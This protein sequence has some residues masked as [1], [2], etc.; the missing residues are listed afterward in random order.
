MDKLS[1]EVRLLI[2]FLLVGVVLTVSNYLSPTPAPT[3]TKQEAKTP[4]PVAEATAVPTATPPPAEA[5]LTAQVQG[6]QPTDFAINTNV[7]TV[8]F[9]NRGATVR[10]WI[11]N[12]Y[13]DSNGKPLD[14]V[15]QSALTGKNGKPVPAPFSLYFKQQ[16]SV[17]LNNKLYKVTKSDD[18]LGVTFEWSDGRITSKKTFQFAKDSYLVNVTSLVIENGMQLPHSMVWRGGFGDM[19]A[20]NPTADQDA[21]YYDTSNSSLNKK[22]ASDA[23]DGPQTAIGLYAFAGLEDKYFAGV[24]LPAGSGTLELT[25]FSDTLNNAAGKEEAVVGAAIGGSGALNFEL[26]I[27]P[28]DADYLT[29]VDKRLTQ[30]IDW[31][32]AGFIAKP[33]FAVLH[34]LYNNVTNNWGWAIVLMTVI[35]NMVLFPLRLT[36][37]KSSKRMQAIQPLVNQINERYKGI[38][39][40]DP[41][42]SNQQQELM[43]LY[44][45]HDINPV[46]GCVP[47]LLQ[48]PFFFALYRVISLVIELRGAPWL[49]VSDL[50]S[51]ETLAIR[52]L[53]L[54]LVIT[55][56]L[57]QKMTPTPGADP[58]QQRMMMFMPLLFGY[59]F[60]W[61]SAGLVLYWLTSNVVGIGQQWL[62]NRITPAPATAVV[63]PPKKKK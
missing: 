17:D 24:A 46:G 10:N 9:S 57:Q 38:P 63:V 23:K 16:P 35:I 11:L 48:I 5:P 53:P 37:M 21:L 28:K 39:M 33:L 42:K 47:M 29:T 3:Q 56:F 6:D 4:T 15:N 8:V 1:M 36:S 31:G 40:S 54:L 20:T 61:A 25:T 19:T 45:K 22:K 41:R 62:L 60:W 27:G 34:W 13:K 30:I 52:I 2:A 12:K 55:Q 44:K 7:H 18:G 49:W 58:T 14:L 50:S 43:D 59:M 26:Y 32:W 51:P